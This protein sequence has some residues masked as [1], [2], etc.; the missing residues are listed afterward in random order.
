[1]SR[2]F[3]FGLA[4]VLAL[5]LFAV[6]GLPH[7]PALHT[8]LV[9]SVTLSDWRRQNLD[10]LLPILMFTHLGGATFLLLAAALAAV[11]LL[12]RRRAADAVFLAFT[13][14]GGRLLVEL[15]KHVIDRPRPAFDLHPVTTFSQSFPSGHAGNSM[16]TYL[17]I[18]LIALPERWRRTGVIAAVALSLAVGLTRPLLGVHWPSDVVGGWLFGAAWVWLCLAARRLTPW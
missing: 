12:A 13:V 4:S 14:L 3:L 8:D 6:L 5:V 16:V 9:I 10:Q 15:A 11:T 7:G 2:S 18:A 1:M 17:A